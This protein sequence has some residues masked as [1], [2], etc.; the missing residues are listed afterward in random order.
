MAY[1]I[2]D[3]D[4]T[5]ATRTGGWAGTLCEVLVE[6]GAAPAPDP[7]ALRP[8]LRQAFPWH[9][10]EV[11]RTPGPPDAWWTD[12]APRFGA[13]FAALADL[14]ED[15][16]LRLA[17]RVRETYL[18]PDA[19]RLYDDALPAIETLAGRG[20]KHV[21]LSN[22][23]PELETIVERLGIAGAFERVYSSA[24]TGAEKPNPAAFACVFADFPAA[25]RGWMIG[26]NPVADVRGGEGVGLRA[27][28]VRRDHPDARLRC[29][30][31]GEVAGIVG[32][33]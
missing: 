19:W 4:G 27:I 31:L 21:L 12:L 22:H 33:P 17:A 8:F 7:E 20:W 3:F 10:H 6:A 2:W 24:C 23:V 11:V 13:A 15:E 30:S 16:A 5:L 9:A 28:L 25:R 32:D 26:D 18:R 29:T 1:L 14:A